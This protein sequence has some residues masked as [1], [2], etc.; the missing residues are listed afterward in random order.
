MQQGT[1]FGVVVEKKKP[2]PPK[3]SPSRSQYRRRAWE[4]YVS[5]SLFVSEL[6]ETKPS[7]S[8]KA[9]IEALAARHAARTPLHR[10]DDPTAPHID[11]VSLLTRLGHDMWEETL[12]KRGLRE[13]A[14]GIHKA[15]NGRFRVRPWDPNRQR[16]V[17][18]KNG[19]AD[20]YGEAV[21][22]LVAYWKR[23]GVDISHTPPDWFKECLGIAM[24]LQGEASEAAG[25]LAWA[26][27][28]V[29]DIFGDDD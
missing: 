25:G 19:Y 17:S 13:T 14:A 7:K 22:K 12:A 21:D 1:L 2:R 28:N 29:D 26:D 23:R 6:F 8:R 15:D 11:W 5:T 18:M 9:R 16:H 24:H 4:D 20:T 10:P 3:P 27:V